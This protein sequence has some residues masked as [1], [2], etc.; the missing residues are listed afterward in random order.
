MFNQY[1]KSTDNSKNSFYLLLIGN[2]QYLVI[3][4]RQL[5]NK[6]RSKYRLNIG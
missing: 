3:K 5:V 4:N 2:D 6:H 1:F